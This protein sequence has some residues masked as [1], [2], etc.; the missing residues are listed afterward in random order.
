[1]YII[2]VN[3]LQTVALQWQVSEASSNNVSSYLIKHIND[4]NKQ[5]G[6]KDVSLVHV[7]FTKKLLDPRS[8]VCCKFHVK[9]QFSSFQPRVILMKT[10][11][12]IV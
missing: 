3:I 12:N 1:M 11:S 6:E 9:I 5:K 10:D 7:S 2:L 4:T 8:I